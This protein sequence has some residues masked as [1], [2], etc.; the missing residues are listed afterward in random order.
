MVNK[1]KA[2]G[3]KAE[4]AVVRYART[5]G[6]PAAERL[7]L[8][9]AADRGDVRLCDAAP[10]GHPPIVLGPVVLEVKAGGAAKNAGAVRLDVWLGETERERRAAGAD[11]AFLVVQRI[12]RVLP[13]PGGWDAV[14]TMKT[15]RLLLDRYRLVSAHP[16]DDA[17]IRMHLADAL[18]LLRCAGYGE[19]VGVPAGEAALA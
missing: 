3:T 11:A 19:P 8:A 14:M 2:I 5:A 13:G 17:P 16:L 10:S 6:F 12:N 7:A 1:P 18:E 9:G 4:T 15:L